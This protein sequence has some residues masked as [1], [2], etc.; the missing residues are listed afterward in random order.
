MQ[1]ALTEDTMIRN[2]NGDNFFDDL[3][4]MKLPEESPTAIE[5]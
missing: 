3:T 2:L 4:L 5:F 1:K